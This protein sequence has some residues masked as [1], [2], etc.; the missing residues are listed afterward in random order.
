MEQNNEISKMEMEVKK[1]LAKHK[2]DEEY[3]KSCSKEQPKEFTDALEFVLN[4]RQNMEGMDS[5]IPSSDLAEMIVTYNQAQPVGE[6]NKDDIIEGL[7]NSYKKET[8]DTVMIIRG[9]YMRWLE[10]KIVEYRQYLST[11]LIE[12][13]QEGRV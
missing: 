5:Y 3:K 11:P 12:G 8:G 9:G 10:K 1:L 13:Q 6:V 7:R 4:Y 2:K